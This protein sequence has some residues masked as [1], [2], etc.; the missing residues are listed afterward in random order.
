MSISLFTYLWFTK[1]D[2]KPEFRLVSSKYC[3]VL[4]IGQLMRNSVYEKKESKSLIVTEPLSN[5]RVHPT[6]QFLNT[7]RQYH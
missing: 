4:A 2:M 1:D 7:G 5:S 6:R 3:R